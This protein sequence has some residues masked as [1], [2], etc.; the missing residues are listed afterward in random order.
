M[1]RSRS[2]LSPAIFL[3][4]AACGDVSSTTPAEQAEARAAIPPLITPVTGSHRD[5]DHALSL[6][7][8]AA[9]FELGP[10]TWTWNEVEVVAESGP[11][12]SEAVT[13]RRRVSLDPRA[14]AKEVRAAFVQDSWALTLVCEDQPCIT[15]ETEQTVLMNG[16][17]T[18]ES[19]P[20][21][22]VRTHDIL[23]SDY[24]ERDKAIAL[25][26]RAIGAPPR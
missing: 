16:D 11:S 6:R 18:S 19:F 10:E 2:L 3:V 8:L 23:F 5:G 4:I 15:V 25:I 9:D 26:R 12:T 7:W 20:P 14:L 21:E 22:R 1:R 13:F 17:R 24:P